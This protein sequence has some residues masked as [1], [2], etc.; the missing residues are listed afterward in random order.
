MTEPT[1]SSQNRITPMKIGVTLA[2]S[3]SLIFLGSAE[4][5]AASGGGCSGWVGNSPQGRA[6][7]SVL[8][9]TH[10]LRPDGYYSFTAAA[11]TRSAACR[12]SVNLFHNGVLL[13]QGLTYIC[14]STS[15]H[16]VGTSITIGSGTYFSVLNVYPNG[17]GQSG[18][19]SVQSPIETG[20]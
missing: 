1:L 5:V 8:A 17:I 14:G 12:T 3:I 4:A 9:G 15:G 20:P 7:I 6:C 18:A 13:N 19:Y 10:T 16:V 11:T 2:I